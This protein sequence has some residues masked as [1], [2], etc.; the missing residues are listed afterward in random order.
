[1]GTYIFRWPYEADEVFV[2][3]TFD[4]WG[5]TVQLDKKGSVF[6][7]EVHLPTADEKIQYKFVVDGSWTTDPNAREEDDG[8]YNT[9]NVLLPEEITKTP[10]QAF[11]PLTDQTTPVASVMAGVTPDSTTAALAASVP[12]ESEEQAD[13]AAATI[14]SAAPGSTTAELAKD[15]PL[16]KNGEVLP[17]SF[18]ETPANEANQ[19][20]VNPIPASNGIGNPVQLKPGQKVPD[21]SSLHANTIESTVR[22]DKAGY[23]AD[24]SAPVVPGLVPEGE[25][26]KAD[27]FSV[28]PVS[29]NMIPES[30]LPMDTP[31]TTD[32]GLPISSAAPVATTAALAAAV[33]FTRGVDT[34]GKEPASDVPD[35]VKDSLKEAHEDPE[36]A[37]SPGAVQEKKA[38]E[39]ELTHKVK[40][41]DSTGTPAPTNGAIAASAASGVPGVVQESLKEAH[42]GPEAA[43][44][45]EA[46]REKQIFEDELRNK[47]PPD[48]S[49]GAP[50]P[51]Y[52]REPAGDVPGVVKK[53]LQ[54]AHE[55]PEAAA[56]IQ[57]VEEKK[58]IEDEIKQKVK[59][60]DAFGEPAPTLSAA[61]AVVAP[62]PTAITT[63]SESAAPASTA[64]A[65]TQ[66]E[67]AKVAPQTSPVPGPSEPTVTTGVATAKT[68]EVSEGK[69]VAGAGPSTSQDPTLKETLRGDTG[70]GAST[71]QKPTP[72]E[73]LRGESGAGASTSQNPTLKETLREE[74]K[75]KKRSSGFFKKLKE[76]FK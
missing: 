52:G 47:V 70:A 62:A 48:E 30:S 57:A 55:P 11:I 37:A 28:P 76:K 32:T 10:A 18:P 72:K 12:K 26:A 45:A 34:N 38:F 24:A 8:S 50:A 25:G 46:V 7:K 15:V 69:G 39:D 17:G 75:K 35:V 19:V 1:M 16:E 41:D 21:P 2:T 63:K 13:F 40:P 3:G 36:A 53:S 61:S 49:V 60:N 56:S 74:P 42:E 9:N 20:S 22:T 68:T 23:E 6:E 43:A 27:A 59:P 64:V 4:D 66:P 58:E 29:N 5:K 54:E 67:S 14:S 31:S 51:T 73:T 44:S 65:T 33:P 71:S